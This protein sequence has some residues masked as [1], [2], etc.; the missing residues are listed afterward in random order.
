MTVQ[1][2]DVVERSGLL[3]GFLDRNGLA[4]AEISPLADDCSFRRYFRVHRGA[5]HYVVMDAPPDLEDVV[6][7]AT[8]SALLN[9]FGYSAPRVLAKDTRDGFLLLDDFGDATYTRALARGADE[10][11][12]YALA[13]DVLVDLG[14]RPIN[15]IPAT[16][17]AYDDDKLLAEA[18]MFVD[19]YLVPGLGMKISDEM[20]EGYLSAWRDCLPIFREA[21]ECLVLRDY[22]VDNLM[23]IAARDGLGACGLL[24][25][26]DAV[27][28]PSSYDVVSL[29]Q[30]SRRDISEELVTAMLAQYFDAMGPDIDRAAFLRSYHA[31]GA[32]RA[33]KVFGIFTRLSVLYGNHGYLEHI[34]RL[35][36][37]T[38]ANLRLPELNGVW[39]WIDRVVPPEMRLTPRPGGGV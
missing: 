14:H 19:W 21:P 20:R 6:P 11:A 13:L 17:P 33:L 8:L 12:L 24:D 2:D 25:F 26:Q 22:H 36:R 3:R 15:T 28:G 7:F 1:A 10:R 30:D 35:W 32:Q 39:E 9:G 27:I 34:P 31:F 23:V 29:L 5:E 37:H 16:I 4:A 18:A 38:E